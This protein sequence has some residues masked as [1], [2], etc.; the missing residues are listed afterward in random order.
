V[1]VLEQRLAPRLALAVADMRRVLDER[2]RDAQ[3]RLRR[4]RRR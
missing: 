3:V 2:E 4:L 1:H